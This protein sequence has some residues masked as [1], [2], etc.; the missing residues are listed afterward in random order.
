[1]K[2]QGA[3][4]LVTGL[5]L[6]RRIN[7][8]SIQPNSLM[9]PYDEIV[10]EFKRN[11]DITNLITKFGV[12][13]ID[14]ALHASR[15][16]N[17]TSKMADLIAVLERS[18]NNTMAGNKLERLT[19]KLQQGDDVDWE[20]VAELARNC[21]SGI[22]NGFA[23]LDKVT[24]ME[25]PFKKTGFRALDEH[26]GGL[27]EV[28][29]IIV[30]ASPGTGKT[31]FMVQLAACWVIEHREDKVVIFTLEMLKEELKMRFNEIT[32]L[33]DEEMSR[34]YIEDA[35]MTPEET[36]S[37]AST[38][39]KVGLVCVDFA[40][41]LIRGETNESAM[42]HIYRTYMLGAKSLHVPIVVLAQLNRLYNGG[43]PRPK[44]IRYT[45]L[46]EALAWGIFM[47]YNP[48][49]NWFAESEDN[50]LL[51]PEK[52]RA[53]II[54]WKLRGGFRVHKKDYPGAVK[55]HFNGTDGWHCADPGRWM[56]LT[57]AI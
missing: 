49:I 43:I 29:Q 51:P 19:R 38:V 36:L 22:G 35:P 32:T 8:S 2:W 13:P 17:G 9:P 54:A 15:N 31:T 42:A 46:A 56:S 16:V 11:S 30:G 57:E 47:L 45:S 5:V 40:D 28:G 23:S 1:M 37:K 55:V 44:H 25:V 12:A 52:D 20:Q 26:F 21:T 53:Y 6:E 34:I 10:E 7:V 48:N 50:E 33:T 24:A 39:D 18:K 4:E 27:P 14:T 41:L 3:T